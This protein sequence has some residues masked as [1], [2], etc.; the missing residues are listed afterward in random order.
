[1][2][3]LRVLQRSIIAVS[4]SVDGGTWDYLIYLLE[5]KAVWLRDTI[6]QVNGN[7]AGNSSSVL[8]FYVFH[9]LVLNHGLD[10]S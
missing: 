6:I 4:Q 3:P 8:G 5:K 1:M 2:G 9:G 7:R 10:P